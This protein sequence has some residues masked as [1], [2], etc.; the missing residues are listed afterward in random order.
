MALQTAVDPAEAEAPCATA[1]AICSSN[2]LQPDK[3]FFLQN[4]KKDEAECRN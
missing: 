3:V 1:R 2:V 4:N